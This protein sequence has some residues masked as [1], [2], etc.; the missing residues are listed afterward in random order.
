MTGLSE[1]AQALG[2][3]EHEDMV[4]QV[5][6]QVRGGEWVWEAVVDVGFQGVR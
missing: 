3:Y 4:L 5:L 1:E 6:R 2:L